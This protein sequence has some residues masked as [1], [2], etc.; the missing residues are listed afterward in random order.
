MHYYNFNIG[1]Y[2][3]HTMHL[4]IEEDITYR[5]LLDL[6][7]DTE[8]PIPTDIH[9]VSRRLRM[10]SEV[11]ESVL[12]EFFILTEEGY[13]NHR[14]D[15]EIADYHAY[16]DKQRSNGKLGGRPK[17]SNGKPIANPSQTQAEPKKSLNNNQ[18][19]T[20]NKQE[21]DSKAPAVQCPPG[22][23]ETTWADFVKHRKAKKAPITETAMKGIQREADKAGMSLDATLQIMCARG[24]TG[25]NAEWVKPD[26]E[27]KLTPAEQSRRAAGIAIFGNLEAQRNEL[28]TINPSF[29]RTLDSENIRDD[30]G[31]LRIEVD[32]YVEDRSD[33]I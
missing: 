1:D 33:F 31:P 22:I 17:K 32:E 26:H 28:R 24:W 12:N 11:V 5:R 15:A 20:T 18:Q 21:T 9:W 14:A 6:Y 30:A 10:G 27:K 7:Y 19:T 3:K 2:I 25:F 4:T 13:R 8:A 16:I 23:L 29:T